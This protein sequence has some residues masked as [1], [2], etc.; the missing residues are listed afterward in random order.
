MADGTHH[1]L[2][3]PQSEP[4]TGSC[5][6]K[7]SSSEQLQ[8]CA[9]VCQPRRAGFC[10]AEPWQRTGRLWVPEMGARALFLCPCPCSPQSQEPCGQLTLQAGQCCPETRQG[11]GGFHLTYKPHQVWDGNWDR[12]RVPLLGEWCWAGLG[13]LHPLGA[14]SQHCWSLGSPRAPSGIAGQRT[15][16]SPLGLSHRMSPPCCAAP[17]SLSTSPRAKPTDPILLTW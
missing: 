17:R 13:C 16:A 15:P 4:S 1:A 8:L 10:W 11:V 5:G 14:A 7:S 2:S 6:H 9:A 12:P 3:T